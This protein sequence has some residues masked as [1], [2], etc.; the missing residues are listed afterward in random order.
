M[1]SDTKKRGHLS[2]EHVYDLVM[3]VDKP[4]MVI[5]SWEGITRDIGP[6]GAES[7]L[8]MIETLVSN[9]NV[10]IVFVSETSDITTLDYLVDGVVTLSDMDGLLEKRSAREITLDK[11]RGIRRKRKNYTFTL[12]G[13]RFKYFPP[14]KPIHLEKFEI[15]PDP[16]KDKI[17]SGIPN[18]DK[19]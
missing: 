8:K 15:I 18:L 5:D 12:N 14:L 4:M 3:R 2:V 17:S 11:L 6:K 19:L 13:G 16:E 10:N 9:K 1:V 7:V